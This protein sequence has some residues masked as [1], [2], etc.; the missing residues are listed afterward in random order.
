MA[1][2]GA[3]NRGE[4]EWRTTVASRTLPAWR[5]I[6]PRARDGFRWIRHFL[7][8][9]NMSK[10]PMVSLDPNSLNKL[11]GCKILV[12]IFYKASSFWTLWWH[13]YDT[14]I[15]MYIM[16]SRNAKMKWLTVTD[17]NIGRGRENMDESG[18]D[19]ICLHASMFLVELLCHLCILYDMTV[20]NYPSL[21]PTWTYGLQRRGKT[22]Y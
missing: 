7:V 3:G 14:L 6:E 21:H 9:M 13:W 16:N 17:L 4:A 2:A 18:C 10:R 22:I 19:V 1:G 12:L 15:E 5:L 8:Y 20:H 11:V